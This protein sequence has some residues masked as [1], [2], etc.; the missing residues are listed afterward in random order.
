MKHTKSTRTYKDFSK[1]LKME[2]EAIAA[3]K[4]EHEIEEF[5]IPSYVD[6]EWKECAVE[7]MT[8]MTEFL[9]EISDGGKE[10]VSSDYI[11]TTYTVSGKGF[12]IKVVGE[13]YRKDHSICDEELREEI[14]VVDLKMQKEE[15]MLKKKQDET[16]VSLRWD[17]FFDGK[18]LAQL[19][20]ELKKYKF[21]AKIK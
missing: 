4:L 19:K 20:T 18:T 21:P 15:K 9:R 8:D 17:E 16:S 13:A 7:D 5:T 1:F 10:S 14:T 2:G 6:G 12:D 11:T 3:I